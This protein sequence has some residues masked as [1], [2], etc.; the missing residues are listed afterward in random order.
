MVDLK[1]T[2]QGQA[3][4]IKSVKIPAEIPSKANP[5]L[6]CMESGDCVYAALLTP[7]PLTTQAMEDR[8]YCLEL[9][10]LKD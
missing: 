10:V 6:L 4:Y 9:R 5:K 3:P 2:Q 8:D 1:I 7:Y